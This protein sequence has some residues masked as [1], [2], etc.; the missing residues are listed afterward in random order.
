MNFGESI[1]KNL[2]R[3][4]A[5]FNGRADRPEFWF[6]MLF[7]S[8]VEILAHV[9]DGVIFGTW[10]QKP[11]FYFISSLAFL[12]PYAGLAW[13]RV[14]DV[15]LPGWLSLFPTLI[16]AL[17][18]LVLAGLLMVG[19]P[20]EEDVEMGFAIISLLVAAPFIIIWCLPSKKL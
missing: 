17:Y 11:F 16:T 15:G 6:F 12:L 10:R 3:S 9:I 14:V 5:D 7:W 8:I 19:Q 4:Y 1:K 2:T 20:L 18:I 13:R